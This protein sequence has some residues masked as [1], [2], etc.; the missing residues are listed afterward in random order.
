MK[1]GILGAAGIVGV[2]LLSL[3]IKHK[4]INKIYAFSSSHNGKYLW[5]LYP[6]LKGVYEDILLEP[7]IEN[8]GLCDVIFIALPHGESMKVAENILKSKC[9]IIDLGADFRFDDC[10]KF[11]ETYSAKH[12]LSQYNTMFE[13]GIC[14]VN[15]KKIAKNSKYIACPGCIATAVVLGIYPIINEKL[16]KNNNFIID[17]KVGSS[18]GGKTISEASM[19]MFKFNSIRAYKLVYHRHIEE[20]ANYF[21][22]QFNEEIELSLNCYSVNMVRGVLCSIYFELKDEV[23]NTRL[24][25]IFTNIYRDSKFVR[26]F[27]HKIGKD[28]HPNPQLLMGSNFCDIS[29]S[30]RGNKCVIL[31]AIDNL[32]KGSAG[33][34]FQIFNIIN[35]FPETEGIDMIPI[36]P[37]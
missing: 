5:H 36:Y 23:D 4:K 10:R 18:G 24:H 26:I 29:V 2:Q 30:S 28:Q 37:V 32:M 11:E 9:K 1:I 13:Y 14:E 12:L 33:Q 19:H 15:H 27:K 16:A 7:T 35:G 8:L 3:A 21:N 34:A 25:S 17:A 31:V 22:C 20:I 6:H